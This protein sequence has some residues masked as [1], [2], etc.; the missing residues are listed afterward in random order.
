MKSKA[1]GR[2][3]TGNKLNSRK[4]RVRRKARSNL[5]QYFCSLEKN[6]AGKFCVR[7]RARFARQN[8]TLSVYFVAVSFGQAMKK[9]EQSLRFL[10]GNEER[11]WF[12]GMDRSDDPNLA[13]DL[14]GSEGL[15]MDRR[16][17]FPTQAVAVSLAPDR[18]LASGLLTPVRRDFSLSHQALRAVSD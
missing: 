12:W 14:L 13:A 8:W 4:P 17:E 10:Q 5:N 3:K 16:A 18:P 7:I 2:Q 15:R 1:N 6:Q 11:L 9:L